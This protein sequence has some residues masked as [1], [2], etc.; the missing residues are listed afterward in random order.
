VVGAPG[1]LLANKSD[2]HP[3][4][5]GMK[6]LDDFSKLTG[7]PYLLT[8]AKTGENVE[9][10]FKILGELMMIYRPVRAAEEDF[11]EIKTTKDVLDF[12]MEDFCKQYGNWND[13]MAIIEANIRMIGLDMRNPERHQLY[14]LI[15][16]LY[17]IEMYS[18]GAEKAQRN[19]ARRL[20][21]LRAV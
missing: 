3:W 17:Y 10:A 1:I 12:I 15:E 9:N 21:A 13:A 8:S 18:L 16:K 4:E 7:L 2:L 5:I 11:S 19:K 6:E 14:L 20:G